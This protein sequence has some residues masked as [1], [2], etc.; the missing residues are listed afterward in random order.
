MLDFRQQNEQELVFSFSHFLKNDENKSY[1][2]FFELDTKWGKPDITT[3]YY[4]K[5]KTFN[6]IRKI[7]K[8]QPLPPFCQI[9]Q[10]AM[11]Y[12]E[13]EKRTSVNRLQYFLRTTKNK[14][15]DI[16]NVLEK[17]K[18]ISFYDQYHLRLLSTKKTFVIDRV[19]TIEAKLTNWKKAI[20]QAKRHL[21]FTNET[22][23][24]KSY[25]SNKS[26]I[27]RISYFCKKEGIGLIF[28]EEEN[29][30]SIKTYPQN[31]GIISS[32]I[33]WFLNELIIDEVL[34]ENRSIE[35]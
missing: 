3:I 18:L 16:I 6:R 21:W 9:C 22:Y 25:T 8:N 29:S 10:Y 33:N 28:Q 5:K 14:T 19:K 31:E 34:N 24:L 30:F 11:T 12:F 13:K 2:I 17:R 15:I 26:Y 27:D 20:E 35:Y 1:K 23:V 7:N 4:N 32:P